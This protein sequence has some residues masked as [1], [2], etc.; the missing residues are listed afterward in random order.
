MRRDW[1]YSGKQLWTTV[2]YE[3]V[4]FPL[5]LTARVLTSIKSTSEDQDTV[6]F[7]AV[8]QIT[9]EVT[10]SSLVTQT[11]QAAKDHIDALEADENREELLAL[12]FSDATSAP[13]TTPFTEYPEFQ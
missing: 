3:P 9:G 10:I 11:S 4:E 2:Q 13:D 6:R 12:G 7:H 5:T 1:S 8:A